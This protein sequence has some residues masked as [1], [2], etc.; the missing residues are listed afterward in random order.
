MHGQIDQ[1]NGFIEFDGGAPTR[2]AR[3][4][5]RADQQQS[6]LADDA[7]IAALCAQ[8]PPESAPSAL[9]HDSAQVGQICGE[10]GAL[11]LAL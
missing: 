9:M 11:G 10:I 5:S 2:A 7:R 1:I 3:V 8:V 6:A 4:L